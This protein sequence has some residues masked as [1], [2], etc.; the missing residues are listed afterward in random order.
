MSHLRPGHLGL[1]N[2]LLNM[3]SSSSSP[4]LSTASHT[5]GL[6]LVAVVRSEGK[7]FLIWRQSVVLG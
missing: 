2:P 3:F 1:S 5:P 7:N 4:A 6:G